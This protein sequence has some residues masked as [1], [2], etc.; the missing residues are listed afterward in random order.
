M[1]AFRMVRSLEIKPASTCESGHPRK[2][3]FAAIELWQK[4]GGS[5]IHGASNASMR[6]IDCDG[7]QRFNHAL[8]GKRET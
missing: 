2:V 6:E 3:P 1:H 8:Q 5:A 7:G 4:S